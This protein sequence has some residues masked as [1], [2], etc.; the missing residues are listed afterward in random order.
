[1]GCLP[2]RF[3]MIKISIIVPIYN[4]E[5]YLRRCLESLVNQTLEEIEIILVNDASPDNS[6]IIMGEYE[7][8]YP[9]K[10]KCIYLEENMSQGGARNKGIETALGEYI[11]FV[12]SDDW[13]HTTMCEKLYNKAIGKNYDIVGCDF[14]KVDEPTGKKRRNSLYFRQ[15]AGRLNQRKKA[16]LLFMFPVPWAKLIRRGLIIENQLYFPAHM[17]YEDAAVVPLY[18]VYADTMGIVEKPLY[19]YNIREESTSH[20]PDAKHHGDSLKSGDIIYK[21][22]KDRGLSQ[23][24]EEAEGLYLKQ[25]FN[26]LRKSVLLFD[27]IDKKELKYIGKI[28]KKK[29]PECKKNHY[30]Y[31]ATDA[32]GRKLAELLNLDIKE[33]LAIHEKE[34][35]REPGDY[36]D[37]FQSNLDK[38]NLIFDYCREHTLKAATWGAGVKGNDFLSVVD[39]E[40]N[41]ISCVID[42]QESKQGETTSTGHSIVESVGSRMDID[43]VIIM[44][45]YHYRSIRHAIKKINKEVKTF[46]LDLYLLMKDSKVELFID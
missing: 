33:I 46:N 26:S 36:N 44:D 3:N 13:I 10:V 35:I 28:L 41:K 25:L 39:K 42:S 22:F 37:Y 16:S 19:Y 14:Y 40:R 6:Y 4:S 23:F 30:Y 12:D 24:H 38:I 43:I 8:K 34:N 7:Q 32:V 5:S 21:E 31:L 2:G 18:F 29:Y 1:M 15:Q 11:M 17:K 9:D 20:L 45:K 27:T